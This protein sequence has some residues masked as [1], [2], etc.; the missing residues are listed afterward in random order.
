MLTI[1]QSLG[2]PRSR[3]KVLRSQQTRRFS[4]RVFGEDLHAQRVL[5]LANGVVGVLTAAVLS[6]HAVGRA[7]AYVAGITAKSGIKQVDRML[8]NDG[9]SLDTI[10]AAWVRF[11]VGDVPQLCL[12]IDWTDFEKDDH[13]TLC[14]YLVTRQGRATPLVWKTVKKSELKDRQ[15]QIEL[16]FIDQL[17]SWIP[18]KVEITLLGDRGFGKV[19]LYEVLETLGWHFVI[20]FRGDILVESAEG[21][22]RTAAGWVP[23]N[24]HARLLAAVHVTRKKQP[25]AAVVVVKAKRMKEPWCLATSRGVAAAQEIVRLYGRRFSIEETFRDTKDLHF[26]MGLSAT[27]IRDAGRRDRLLML[28]AVAHTLLTLLGQASEGSGLDRYLKANTVKHRTLSLYR[29]GQYWYQAIPTMRDEWLERLMTAFDRIVREHPF[30]SIAF[31][32]E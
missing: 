16:A 18:S 7:Y 13:T 15:T 5:S 1:A 20:R 27:H 31:A 6:V 32:P 2:S 24:G 9:L 26:G 14:A 21:E 22:V 29:Q 8:S 23:P 10:L 17:S 28:V 30:F 12:A 25:V 4:D 11:V 19:E 3:R